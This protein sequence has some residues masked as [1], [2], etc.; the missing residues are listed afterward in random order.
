[1]CL[2]CYAARVLKDR[3]AWISTTEAVVLALD[4]GTLQHAPHIFAVEGPRHGL[5]LIDSCTF[6]A[7]TGEKCYSTKAA[8]LEDI[9][10][11]LRQARAQGHRRAIL[12]F[13]G[14]YQFA[15]RVGVYVR[16]AKSRS[17]KAA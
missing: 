4:F 14:A 6:D 5:T 17:R 9:Q 1:M 16:P 12:V 10:Q 15:A 3:S 7:M 11:A 13:D 8:R 2:N